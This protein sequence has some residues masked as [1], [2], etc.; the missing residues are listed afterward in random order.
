MVACRQLNSDLV[1]E[2]LRLPGF[3]R[4]LVIDP[5]ADA[6][7]SADGEAVESGG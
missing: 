4:Q 1:G 5:E 6:I 7:I 3:K 2:R